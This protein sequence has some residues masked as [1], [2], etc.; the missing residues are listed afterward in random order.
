MAIV[1]QLEDRFLP[2]LVDVLLHVRSKVQ[3]KFDFFS[4]N[5]NR[6][7]AI[8]LSRGPCSAEAICDFRRSYFPCIGVLIKRGTYLLISESSKETVR[9]VCMLES[10]HRDDS[11][12]YL[13]HYR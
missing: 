4:C 13:K 7:M 3:G 11:N 8:D 5:M 9:T 10:S 2:Y 1:G 6:E 12:V